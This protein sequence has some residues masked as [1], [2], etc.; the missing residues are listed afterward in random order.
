MKSKIML[1]ALL[2]LATSGCSRETLKRTSYETMRNM[3]QQRCLEQDPS[4]APCPKGESYD[5]YQRRRQE[6]EQGQ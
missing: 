3:E 1:L 6:S 5:E 2:A 4:A